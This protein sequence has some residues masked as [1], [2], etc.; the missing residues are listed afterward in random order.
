MANGRTF[1]Y[2]G[3]LLAIVG[4]ILL[5]VGTTTWTYPREVF[6]VNG[7]NLVTGSTTPNYFFNFIGLA[8]LLFGVGSLLSHVELGRR[9]K[10]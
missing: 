6:A 8:I 1:L 10:R 9:S 4:I 2:L 7:M 3:V 5:A